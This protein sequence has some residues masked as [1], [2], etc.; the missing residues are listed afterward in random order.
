[1]QEQSIIDVNKMVEISTLIVVIIGLGA[2]VFGI[3]FGIWIYRSISKP[4]FRLIKATERI[5]AGDL[6]HEFTQGST[7][8][9]DRVEASMGTMVANLKDIVGKIRSTTES[10]AS[11]GGAFRHCPVPRRGL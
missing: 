7:T 11:R 6:G 2:V 5:A 1:M 4:L 10:L 8:S 9:S 3:G